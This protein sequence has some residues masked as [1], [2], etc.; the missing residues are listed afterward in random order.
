MGFPF[1]TLP[2]IA[3]LA[4][5]SPLQGGLPFTT[6]VS[7]KA[8]ADWLASPWLAA[9]REPSAAVLDK[10]NASKETRVPWITP[11]ISVV[12]LSWPGMAKPAAATP[13]PSRQYEA[14]EGV[15][16]ALGA[17]AALFLASTRK[18]AQPGKKAK[19]R[20]GGKGEGGGGH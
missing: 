1:A 13:L 10:R 8:G 17:F 15:L 5:A 12:G 2:L 7:G 6:V 3:L 20:A 11:P 4:A 18:W 9:A 14:A 16:S 19:A